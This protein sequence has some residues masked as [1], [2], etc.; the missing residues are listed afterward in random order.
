[1][2]P[3]RR[4]GLIRQIQADLLEARAARAQLAEAAKDTPE[5]RARAVAAAA[6]LAEELAALDAVVKARRA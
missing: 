3:T 6:G 2:P 1:M 4:E 5:D